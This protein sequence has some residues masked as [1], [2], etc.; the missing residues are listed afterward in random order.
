MSF[1]N[2]IFLN[3]DKLLHVKLW[4]SLNNCRHWHKVCAEGG[5]LFR[6][7]RKV[8]KNWT[9]E[10]NTCVNDKAEK[11]WSHENKF[12]EKAQ[13]LFHG[14]Y[15]LLCNREFD[16]WVS[17]FGTRREESRKTMWTDNVR[18]SSHIIWTFLAVPCSKLHLEL[19]II[20]TTVKIKLF[21]ILKQKGLW[22][23]VDLL[24]VFPGEA[25]TV[26]VP[27]NFHLAVGQVSPLEFSPAL[28]S[29][30]RDLFRVI[31]AAA[32]SFPGWKS[33]RPWEKEPVEKQ[34]CSG[35]ILKDF[36]KRQG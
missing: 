9:D 16:Q 5:T 18:I 13:G 22:P 27:L 21:W 31:G 3:L 36:S 20:S 7:C 2:F 23:G 11:G 12:L 34:R 33:V 4:L 28:P 35:L 1:F 17:A 29:V 24:L 25:L 15:R 14:A 30:K 32:V 10:R 26:Y 8:E 19:S 6:A